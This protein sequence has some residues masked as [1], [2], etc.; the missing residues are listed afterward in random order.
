M[1]VTDRATFRPVETALVM[2]EVIM[3]SYPDSVRFRDDAMDRL[4]G[5]RV[6]RESLTAHQSMRGILQKM[7]GDLE[8]FQRLRTKYLLY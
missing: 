7:R 2:L 6:I 8:K 1:A 3:K 5:S 4:T